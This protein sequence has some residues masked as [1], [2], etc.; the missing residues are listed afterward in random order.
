MQPRRST[1]LRFVLA[2]AFAITGHAAQ[3]NDG[4]PDPGFGTDGVVQTGLDGANLREVIALPDGRLV[5]CGSWQPSPVEFTQIIV[6]QFLADGS[7]DPAFGTDGKVL[8]DP[9]P[10]REEC[11]GIA[12]EPDGRL[13]IAGYEFGG[14]PVGSEVARIAARLMPDGSLDT[15]FAAGAGVE[16]FVGAYTTALALQHDGKILLGGHGRVASSP[17]FQVQRLM[18]DGSPDETF[19]T[20]SVA[21]IPFAG[22]GT[23]DQMSAV[24][25][26]AAGRIVAAGTSDYYGDSR[27]AL[28]RLLADGSLDPEFGSGGKTQGPIGS[29]GRGMAIRHDGSLIVAGTAD[30]PSEL[31]AAAMRVLDDGLIDTG[32]GDGD[33]IARLRWNDG[34][35]AWATWGAGVAIQDDDRIVMTGFTMSPDARTFGLLGRLDAQ[36]QPDTGFGSNG[37]ETIDLGNTAQPDQWLNGVTLSSGRAV[38][39]GYTADVQGNRAGA[40]ARFE[41]DGIF[42]NGF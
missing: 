34:S 1:A 31:N 6:A 33:G 32:F 20:A 5:A 18:P 13:V 23:T 9:T 8:I 21:S 39:V 35:D 7:P 36:G 10:Y 15:T 4:A 16:T 24:A 30:E 11:T 25:F 3:A 27:M 17:V 29:K 26:D 42:A 2:A 37:A 12:R 22:T 40:I 41:N 38:V 14:T 28:V 19:G